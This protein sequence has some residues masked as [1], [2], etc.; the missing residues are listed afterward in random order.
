[1]YICSIGHCVF[2]LDI[3]TCADENYSVPLF[4]RLQLQ[5]VTFAFLKAYFLQNVKIISPALWKVVIY[6]LTMGNPSSFTT[7]R[8]HFH[9]LRTVHHI[10]QD[11]SVG[12]R[13]NLVEIGGGGNFIGRPN[14][15]ARDVSCI[16]SSHPPLSSRNQM[17][18]S[19]DILPL[20]KGDKEVISMS[21]EE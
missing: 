17:K 16:S 5:P 14:L 19:V 21:N 15:N 1:M 6:H 10:A 8:I 3:Q 2:F 7:R 13:G 20:F 11:L 18:K 9:F 12:R 4:V